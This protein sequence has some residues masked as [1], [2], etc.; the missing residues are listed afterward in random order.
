[1]KIPKFLLITVLVTVFALFYVYQQ[2]EVFRLAYAGQKKQV[3]FADLLDKNSLLRYNIDKNASLV[4]IGSR[5][6]QAPEFEMPNTYRLVKLAQ[7]LENLT[8]AR[9]IYN[10]ESLMSRI[11][12]I[13]RQ[14]EAKTISP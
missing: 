1:M 9:H 11:F 4:C 5:L 12:G 10:K 2:S 6:T 13:K 7:P 8:V 3:K 14:A